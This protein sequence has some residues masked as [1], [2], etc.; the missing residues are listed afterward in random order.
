MPKIGRN[1]IPPSRAF[2]W[3]TSWVWSTSNAHASPRRF[4]CLFEASSM[5]KCDKSSV[6]R[7]LRLTGFW[8][9]LRRRRSGK[10]LANEALNVVLA[11]KI[12]GA[13]GAGP[14]SPGAWLVDARAGP[15]AGPRRMTSAMPGVNRG[16]SFC[17]RANASSAISNNIQN[18]SFTWSHQPL[19]SLWNAK[20][21]G[22]RRHQE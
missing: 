17:C 6:P 13:T 22:S 19:T 7:S 5:R 20:N 1:A 4:C 9:S 21:V 2:R 10:R 8:W 16:P 15:G 14:N 18:R 11:C 3:F 12:S